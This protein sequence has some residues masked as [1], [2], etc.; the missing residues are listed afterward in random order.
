MPSLLYLSSVLLATSSATV[1]YLYIFHRSLGHRIH[2][3]FHHSKLP[4]SVSTVVSLPPEVS[5]GECRAFYDHASRRI[6]RK[7]LPAQKLEDLFTLLLRRNMTAFSRFPQ[8]WI[9]RLNVAPADRITFHA[10]HIRSL[11]FKEG[12]LVCGFYRVQERTPNK[13][14]L[15]LLFEGEVSG[16]L[17]IRFWE[18]SDDVVFCTETIMWT[19]KVNPGQIKRV[20]VPLENPVLR[21]LHEIAAWWL[22][23]SGVTYLQDLKETTS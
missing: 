1:T 10:S 6:A 7:L 19:R 21:F 9:L 8:A 17:V 22:I 13:A 15:E 14:V 18:E 3:E 16:R 2:H 23:D 20:I 4:E 11:Q 5:H 12:D